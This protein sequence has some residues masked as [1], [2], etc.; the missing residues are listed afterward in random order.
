MAKAPRVYDPNGGRPRKHG[1]EVRLAK[2]ET[3]PE[4]TAVTMKD[5][6]RYIKAE[7]RVW[8]RSTP[9]SPTARPGSNWTAN[10]LWWRAR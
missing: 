4:P 6:P 5:T 7:A 3:W 10:S 1:P 8:D 2:P 9:G